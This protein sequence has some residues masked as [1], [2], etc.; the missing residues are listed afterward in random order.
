MHPKDTFASPGSTCNTNGENGISTCKYLEAAITDGTTLSTWTPDTMAPWGCFGTSVMTDEQRTASLEIGQG[1]AN[2][3]MIT[4][5]KNSTGQIC[6]TS[7]SAA[8][9]AATYNGGGKDDW[10]LPSRIEL[11]ALC[12]EFFK[13]RTGVKYS[14][15]NCRGSD[16]F[17]S[18]TSAT[19]AT[20][21]WSFAAGFYWSSSEYF[22]SRAWRQ[23]VFYGSQYGNFKYVTGYVR[24][25]RAF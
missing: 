21:V 9:I 4:V 13:G 22:A 2:T 6:S 16:E 5:A 17:L 15:D 19:N 7:A 14:K 23:N 18:V 25:V 8:N 12:N 3:K 20:P 24:P 10:F 11:D 1:R